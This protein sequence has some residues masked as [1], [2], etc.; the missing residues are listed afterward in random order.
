MRPD[1]VL[2]P[3]ARMSSR[4]GALECHADEPDHHQMK[5]LPDCPKFPALYHREDALMRSKQS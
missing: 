4:F 2:W 5:R 3:G 1:S